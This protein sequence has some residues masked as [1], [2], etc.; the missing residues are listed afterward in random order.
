ML[1]S[2]HRRSMIL[3]LSLSLA[4]TGCSVIGRTNAANAAPPSFEVDVLAQ[5]TP[6]SCDA[7]TVAQD[8]RLDALARADLPAARRL[9]VDT[10]DLDPANALVQ[11]HADV[12]EAARRSLTCTSVVGGDVLGTMPLFHAGQLLAL[13]G[14][15]AREVGYLDDAVATALSS[16]RSRR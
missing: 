14:E 9:M 13:E 3:S 10:G 6:Q 4:A 7:H 12:L 1:K 15:L 2:Y 11:T 5:Y 8:S 16:T